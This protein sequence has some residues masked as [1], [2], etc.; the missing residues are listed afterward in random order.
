[1]ARSPGTQGG[2]MTIHVLN[3]MYGGFQ[4]ARWAHPDVSAMLEVVAWALGVVE[5]RRT[6]EI[7]PVDLGPVHADVSSLVARYSGPHSECQMKKRCQ[8]GHTLSFAN[9]PTGP[10]RTTRRFTRP[11]PETQGVQPARAILAMRGPVG[12][13]GYLGACHDQTKRQPSAIGQH[14]NVSGLGQGRRPW[15]VWRRR[16]LVLRRIPA[17][18]Q[19]FASRAVDL[20]HTHAARESMRWS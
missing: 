1:M 17:G 20:K 9:T 14:R 12:A 10:A 5:R 18:V 7:R 15:C 2:Y 16:R 6:F 13:Q 11:R 4:C 8:R 19:M 3:L